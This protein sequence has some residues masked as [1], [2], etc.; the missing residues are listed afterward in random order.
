MA[1][2]AVVAVVVGERVIAVVVQERQ[3]DD[4]ADSK[5]GKGKKGKIKKGGEKKGARC[6]QSNSSSTPR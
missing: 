3:G 4:P 5:A 6:S 2:V 1:I